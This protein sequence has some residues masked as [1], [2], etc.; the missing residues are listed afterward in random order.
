MNEFRLMPRL[1]GS[2][3]YCDFDGHEIDNLAK[4]KPKRSPTLAIAIRAKMSNLA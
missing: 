1:P 4:A 2:N 3:M